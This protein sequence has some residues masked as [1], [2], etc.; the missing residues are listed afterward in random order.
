MI[1][2]LNPH[3]ILDTIGVIG[4]SSLKYEGYQKIAF[5]TSCITVSWLWFASIA[6]LGRYVGI[7]DRAGKLTKVINKVSALVMWLAAIYL[8]KIF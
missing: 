2:L 8:L 7:K 3:A 1:S 6:L 5:V 4:V